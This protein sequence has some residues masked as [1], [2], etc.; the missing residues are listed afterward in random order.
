MSS[1]QR[2][3]R[4]I[5]VV[6]PCLNEEAVIPQLYHRLTTAADSW[7]RDYEVIVVDDGSTDRTWELLEDICAKDARW[8]AIRLSRNFGHQAAV[9]AGLWHARGDCTAVLD[10]DLQDPPEA[11]AGFLAA[12]RNGC[13]VVYGI[14]TQR[15]EHLFKRAAYAIFYRLLAWLSEIR[16][17]LDAGDFCVMD[18][19]V[20]SLLNGL[21]ERGR[22]LRGLRSWTGF[23]QTGV[24]YERQARA[25]GAPQYTLAKLVRLALDGFFSFSVVPL[26]FAT[27][28]GFV[29]SMLAGFGAVFT[30]VQRLFPDQFAQFGLRPVPGFATTVISIL[31]LGGVQLICLGILGEYL[32]RI[33]EEVKGRPLWVIR[34]AHGFPTDPPRTG[35][36]PR[37]PSA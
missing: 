29:V 5:S 1:Q 15:K 21:P 12:W 11:L 28:L 17:P 22:F 20:V 14:R 8:R 32:G 36:R 27:Y 37:D 3:A 4:L 18:R 7:G 24:P 10:G 19:K 9:S 25:G 35:G 2:E 31:F 23:P 34:D 6:V 13:D 30:F 33:Y 16:I 26:R